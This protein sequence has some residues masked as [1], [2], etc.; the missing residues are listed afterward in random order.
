MLRGD[1]TDVSQ[2]QLT[3]R[4][5]TGRKC[6]P[7]LV[8]QGLVLRPPTRSPHLLPRP[9]PTRGHRT[10]HLRLRHFRNPFTSHTSALHTPRLLHSLQSLTTPRPGQRCQTWRRGRQRRRRG[11]HVVSSVT[12]KRGVRRAAHDLLP[13]ARFVRQILRQWRKTGM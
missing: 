8:P 9:F 5:G 11:L 7:M 13:L 2:H 6:S 3:L 4:T 10:H 1:G 12:R